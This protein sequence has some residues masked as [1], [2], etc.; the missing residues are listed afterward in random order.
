MFFFFFSVLSPCVPLGY[1]WGRWAQ[2]VLA[3]TFL[4][5]FFIYWYC[6]SYWYEGLTQ[7]EETRSITLRIRTCRG[8]LLFIMLRCFIT[9]IADKPYTRSWCAPS[10]AHQSPASMNNGVAGSIMSI[11]SD[12]VDYRCVPTLLNLIIRFSGKHFEAVISPFLG[13][14]EMLERAS[15][16]TRK[17]WNIW[18]RM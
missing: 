2:L 1:P 17:H 11:L 4:Y 3:R 16:G 18:G 13:S 7:R 5:F 10:K 9:V 6:C 12:A 15:M 8:H 14:C